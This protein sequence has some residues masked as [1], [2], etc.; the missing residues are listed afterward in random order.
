MLGAMRALIVIEVEVP[1]G[2]RAG[3][4]FT[5]L[6]WVARSVG[7][8]ARKLRRV[9]E[10]HSVAVHRAEAGASLGLPLIDADLPDPAEVAP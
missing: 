4:R 3:T 7:M 1:D 2:Q 10:V 9:R 8:H 5:R 6:G